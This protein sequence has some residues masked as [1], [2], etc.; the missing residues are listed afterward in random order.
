[1]PAPLAILLAAGKSTRMKSALPKVLHEVCGRPM[2]EYVL[3]AARTAGVGRIVVVI[4]HEADR[5]R[6]A[7]AAYPDLEFALQT[8]QKGTGH[9][10]MMC[11]DFLARHA[12][13]VLVL[14]GDTPLVREESLRA[15]LDEQCTHAAAC[16]IGTAETDANQGLGR[17]VRDAD[18]NFLKIVEQRDATPEQAA[19][20]EI[21][22]GCYAF[23]G[24]SLLDALDR[25]QP[26][27]AQSEYYLTDCPALLK[28]DGRT[29]LASRRFDII[30]ALG[31]NTRAQLAEVER[32]LCRRA[33]ERL[34]AEGVTIIAPD[35]T[36]IDPR[37]AIGRD[38]IVHPFTVISGPV[39]I[40]EN[41]TIGP[42]AV[43][44]GPVEVPAGT[45]VEPFQALRG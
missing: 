8:D 4:G 45:V 40:G 37:A 21:N 23:D 6:A 27:N 38:T 13:P 19:I 41:C 36:S 42:H 12:G 17:I 24:P 39:R 11:R 5:V 15:L 16:V 29:V 43:I 14:A 32:A 35:Q 7:L 1:M 9:A 20:C 34:M 30:E 25:I 10:V 2:I 3:D 22:T 28:A 31:V 44:S 18:R 33:C 26:A